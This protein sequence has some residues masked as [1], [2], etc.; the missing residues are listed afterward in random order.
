MVV[1]PFISK[2]IRGCLFLGFIFKLMHASCFSLGAVRSPQ[3]VYNAFIYSPSSSL[4]TMFA[5]TFSRR[6]VLPPHF[7]PLPPRPLF[8]KVKA[9]AR[10]MHILLRGASLH[11]ILPSR[12]TSFSWRNLT[13][14]LDIAMDAKNPRVRHQVADVLLFFICCQERCLDILH[15]NHCQYD[16]GLVLDNSI[17]N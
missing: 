6:R 14:P 8:D 1:A 10:N 12:P 13:A 2:G 15:A 9:A 7:P 4:H 11:T 16:L 5:M 3:H 17:F